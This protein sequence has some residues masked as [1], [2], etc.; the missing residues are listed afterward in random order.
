MTNVR[1]FHRISN[2][3]LHDF[4]RWCR[5]FFVTNVHTSQLSIFGG[6]PAGMLDCARSWGKE[7]RPQA[8]VFEEALAPG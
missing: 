5:V 3:S 7:S 1:Q 6:A 2:I 8:P 4:E